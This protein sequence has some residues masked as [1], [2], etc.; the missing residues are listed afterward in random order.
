MQGKMILIVLANYDI[1][2]LFLLSI[3]AQASFLLYTS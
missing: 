1:S 3:D 2:A